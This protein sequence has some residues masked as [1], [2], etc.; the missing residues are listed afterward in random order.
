MQLEDGARTYLP[1]LGTK[2]HCGRGC[3]AR[4]VPDIN[5]ITTPHT[6]Q[7]AGEGRYSWL[8]YSPYPYLVLI[9]CDPPYVPGRAR[10][11]RTGGLAV[12]YPR[13]RKLR[14]GGS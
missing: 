8:C 3:L 10:V 14:G 12:V 4:P 2:S 13:Y 11:S 1:I 6:R 9:L 5:V 7:E